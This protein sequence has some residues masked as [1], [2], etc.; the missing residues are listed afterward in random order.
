MGSQQPKYVKFPWSNMTQPTDGSTSFPPVRACIFDMDGLLIDTEHLYTRLTNEIL[1][2]YKRPSLPWSLKAELQGRT[3]PM[4]YDL[5][6][7]WAKLPISREEFF[8]KQSA[9]QRQY[10]PTCH[11]HAGVPELLN[12]LQHA[13]TKLAL[14]TSSQTANFHLKTAHLPELFRHFPDELRITGDDPRVAEGRGKPAPDIFLAALEA[15]NLQCRSKGEREVSPEECLVFEDSVPGISAG[16]RAF[17]RVVWVPYAGL[18][19]VFKDRIGEVLAGRGDARAEELDR[20]LEGRSKELNKMAD[21]MGGL[22]G[23]PGRVGDGWGE[24]LDSLEEFD[25]AKYGIEVNN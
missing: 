15:I 6:Q 1:H 19:E 23:W 3:G 11:P 4:A 8:A 7:A 18:V 14:A 22:K 25:I 2:K 13:G 21:E 12:Q 16:R 5:F 9:L 24:R 17:M 10:F 20:K